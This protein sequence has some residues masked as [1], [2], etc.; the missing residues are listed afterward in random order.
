MDFNHKEIE[1]NGLKWKEFIARLIE[2]VYTVRDIAFTVGHPLRYRLDQE[3]NECLATT[4]LRHAEESE[5]I[6]IN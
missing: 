5:S 1:Q 4:E 2:R 6:Y 3:E